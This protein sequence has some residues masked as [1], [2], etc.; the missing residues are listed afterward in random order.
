MLLTIATP[1]IA[2]TAMHRRS[3]TVGS[4]RAIFTASL[5]GTAMHHMHRCC[6]AVC[7]GQGSC[8]CSQ[9]VFTA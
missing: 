6:L 8:S 4:S 9:E 3:G 7:R 5:Q 2:A 1:M